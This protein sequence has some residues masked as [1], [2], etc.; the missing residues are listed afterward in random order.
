MWH[1]ARGDGCLR[2]QGRLSPRLLAQRPR[3]SDTRSTHYP[4]LRGRASYQ[5]WENK[6]NTT[7]EVKEYKSEKRKYFKHNAHGAKSPFI[8]KRVMKWVREVKVG[9]EG[10]RERDKERKRNKPLNMNKMRS[11]IQRTHTHT[12]THTHTYTHTYIHIHI[13]I[14]AHTHTHTYTHTHTLNSLVEGSL[15]SV[16]SLMTPKLTNNSWI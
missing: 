13:H 11:I 6:W 15:R 4:V 7:V 14:H 2:C 9:R 10:E 8:R 12:H 16:S 5:W 3:E 1:V